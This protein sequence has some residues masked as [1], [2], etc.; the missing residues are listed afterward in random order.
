MIR[1]CLVSAGLLLMT[2]NAQAC[3]AVTDRSATVTMPSDAT[4][5]SGAKKKKK[6]DA[7]RPAPR[8]ASGAGAAGGGGAGA[9]VRNNMDRP[10]ATERYDRDPAG[11]TAAAL[12]FAAS[13]ARCTLPSAFACSIHSVT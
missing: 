5:F 12:S 2:A 6:P 11:A 4:D 10:R 9:P 3:P 1:L 13:N 8:A 7:R